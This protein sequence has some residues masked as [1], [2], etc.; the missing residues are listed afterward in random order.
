MRGKKGTWTGSSSGELMKNLENALP[1]YAVFTK[2][3]DIINWSRYNSLSYLTLDLACC[4]IEMSHV[5]GSRFDIERFGSAPV[6]SPRHADLMIVAGT[7]S[8]KMA[9][10]IKNLYDQMPFPKYV[11]SM[12]SCS[13][14]GGIFNWENSYA[15]VSGVDKIIPVDVF[16]P[17]CPPRPE[18]LLH[19]LVSLQKKISKQKVL[20]QGVFS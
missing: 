3:D 6:A 5:E 9:P 12:G 1:E 20:V 16:V 18:A 10:I 17:G 15:A 8:Y 11:I 4:G 2:L 13:N 14:S 7:I 19:G